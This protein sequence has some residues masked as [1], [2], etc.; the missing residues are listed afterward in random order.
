MN[1]SEY[2]L[3][4]S[5][6]SILNRHLTATRD[7]SAERRPPGICKHREGETPSSRIRYVQKYCRCYLIQSFLPA[8]FSLFL[9]TLFSGC[10]SPANSPT[11]RFYTLPALEP[12]QA[13]KTFQV[14]PSVLIGI[15][16]VKVPE[17]LNR[18][19][20]VTRGTNSL[21][22]FAQFDRWGEPLEPAL[23]RLV[24]RNLGV[25][26]PGA[27]LVMSPWNMSIPVKYQVIMDVVQLEIRLDK[28][29]CLEVQ[30]TVIDLENR[31]M[32]AVKKSEFRQAIMPKD[33]SGLARG[34]SVACA[35]LSA[36]I[37]EKL[38]EVTAEPAA[39]PDSPEKHHER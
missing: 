3:A 22:H 27:A 34:L 39:Q 24:A 29:L 7:G 23:E 15:G 16:P 35:A 38:A 6:K 17:Y 28:D 30:W 11:P 32:L 21:L 2:D 12:G 25:I 19:Q 10:V 4:W 31:R 1:R 33:Y 14:P 9:I 5:G 8:L 37:G 36:E 20:I 13:A 26:L 18:P